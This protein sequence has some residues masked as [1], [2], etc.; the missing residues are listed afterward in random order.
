M[1]G[2]AISTLTADQLERWLRARWPENGDPEEGYALIGVLD[3]SEFESGHIPG[4]LPVPPGEEAH[5]RGCFDTEKPLVVYG[6]E[7]MPPEPQLSRAVDVLASCGYR[8]I[9]IL[10]GGLSQWRRE[11]RPLARGPASRQAG[12]R[13]AR[14]AG[15]RSETRSGRERPSS[16]RRLA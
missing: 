1:D 4:S 16:R 5:L 9:Q 3:P 2:P 8:R 13:R 10:R 15:L 12:G 7:P 11:Q 6:E 14:A